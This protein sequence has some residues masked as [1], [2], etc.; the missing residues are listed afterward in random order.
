MFILD[1]ALSFI[2]YFSRTC[3]IIICYSRPIIQ[4]ISTLKI[5]AAFNNFECNKRMRVSERSSHILKSSLVK[6]INYDQKL[7][8]C[9]LK[10]TFQN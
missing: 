2:L 10:P 1:H 8:K 9:I 6:R 7:G 4:Y 5:L 3:Y